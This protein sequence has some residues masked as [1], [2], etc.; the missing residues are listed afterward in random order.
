MIYEKNK[1]Y[2]FDRND[3]SVSK[4]TGRTFFLL[5]DDNSDY[6]MRIVPFKFQTVNTPDSLKCRYLGNG[7]WEQVKRDLVPRLYEEGGVYEFTVLH[8][9]RNLQGSCVMSDDINGIRFSSVSMGN[10]RFRE[11]QRIRCR[12][13]YPKNE[14]EEIILTPVEESPVN[15]SKFDSNKFLMLPSVRGFVRFF[16]N[17]LEKSDKWADAISRETDGDNEWLINMLV[18]IC[19][20]IPE[21]SRGRRRNLLKVLRAV[22][23]EVIENSSYLE[24]FPLREIYQ[25]KEVLENLATVCDEYLEAL[26][27][28]SYGT[29]T[30][31]ISTILSRLQTSGILFRAE[32]KF[33]VLKALFALGCDLSADA[34]E[35]L[36]SLSKARHKETGFVRDHVPVFI[37][38][39]SEY[40]E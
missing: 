6:T 20:H 2:S 19:S 34:V 36:L 13:G 21:W 33:G 4:E 31:F 15:K 1:V 38:L 11:Y 12:V 8:Q 9:M 39:L 27:L 22:I 25:K 18:N 28:I 16:G 10:K 29:H 23:V 35:I 17:R 32:H 24:G 30:A 14:N 37:P 3:F 26:D 7:R 5:N 40:V